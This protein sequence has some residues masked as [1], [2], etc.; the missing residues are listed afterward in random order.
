MVQLWPCASVVV[1]L[2]VLAKSPLN[3]IFE[4]VRRP[5]PA[6][7]TV[8]SCAGGFDP[9]ESADGAWL[10]YSKDSGIWCLPLVRVRTGSERGAE[11]AGEEEQV[12]R[13]SASRFWTIAAGDLVFLCVFLDFG[14]SQ[15][16]RFCVLDLPDQAL[17]AVG[18][19]SGKSGLGA[20]GLS[21]SPDGHWLLYAQLDR[22]VSHETSRNWRGR[23]CEHLG[24]RLNFD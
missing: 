12:W 19:S 3:A 16:W 15:G 9:A 5:L 11:A 10:Y 24:L 6:L 22:L 17:E 23:P 2:L 1:Q 13:G 8:T 4:M 20:S 7:V 14:A 18:H 21:V